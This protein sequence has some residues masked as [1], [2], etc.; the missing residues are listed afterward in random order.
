MVT[1]KYLGMT[2]FCLHYLL[3]GLFTILIFRDYHY[4]YKILFRPCHIFTFHIAHFMLLGQCYTQRNTIKQRT[5]PA[6]RGSVFKINVELTTTNDASTVCSNSE[7]LRFDQ[8]DLDFVLKNGKMAG[9]E[10]N[11]K[12]QDTQIM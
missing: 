12:H 1:Y 2:S 10:S 6:L 11:L 4:F 7:M 5:I 3:N 8:K 9:N